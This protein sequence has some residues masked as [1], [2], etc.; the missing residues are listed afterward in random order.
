MGVKV[1]RGVG[2]MVAVG[3]A[4]ADGTRVGVKAA[5]GSSVGVGEDVFSCIAWGRLQANKISVTSRLNV[6]GRLDR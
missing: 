2:V 5:V 3:E 1:G 4:V 6:S